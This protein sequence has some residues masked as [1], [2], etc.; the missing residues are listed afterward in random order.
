LAEERG[1]DLVIDMTNTVFS[2]PALEIT[3]DATTA[4]N[5]AYPGK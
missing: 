3:A 2:K 1:F 5:K 4:Y